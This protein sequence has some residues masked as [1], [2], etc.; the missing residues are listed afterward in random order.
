MIFYNKNYNEC[1][2]ILYLID[3]DKKY[4]SQG[5]INFDQND[6]SIMINQL[7]SNDSGISNNKAEMFS[8]IFNKI[9][10]DE[11]ILCSVP[12]H[13][14]NK[15]ETGIS[16]MIKILCNKNNRIDGTE[17]LKRNQFIDK[18]ALGGKSTS[19]IHEQ[20]INVSNVDMIAEKEIILFDDIA[21]TCNSINV[22]KRKLLD[23]GA[24]KVISVALGYAGN[25]NCNIKKDDL[26]NLVRTSLRNN[27]KGAQLYK[28][29]LKNKMLYE[30]QACELAE[31]V[32]NEIYN[33]NNI[34]F[35]NSA[36]IAFKIAQEY[37]A[38]IETLISNSKKIPKD[39][40]NSFIGSFL[41]VQM[42]R[43][44]YTKLDKIDDKHIYYTKLL[45]EV[46][47]SKF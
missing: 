47:N 11:I 39:Y 21:L 35:I 19:E 5:D 14:P 13:D 7:N 4:L 12:S 43:L 41:S 20:S 45:Y 42:E 17:I 22:C 46:N 27:C 34:N 30:K 26:N 32:Y 23:A 38:E 33:S 31:A 18:I 10:S 3:Y 2:S 16:R 25:Q 28:N 6:I 44:G 8:G 15:T 36:E 40:I 37:E 1:K 29:Y 24:K 9:I